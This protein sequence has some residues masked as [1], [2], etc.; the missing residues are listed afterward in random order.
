MSDSVG[1]AHLGFMGQ[2]RD[3]MKVDYQERVSRATVWVAL[4]RPNMSHWRGAPEP[5]QRRYSPAC[6]GGTPCV[7]CRIIRF[8]RGPRDRVS[9]LANG[10]LRV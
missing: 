10:L 3:E 5:L 1:S 2:V 4:F 6:V 7:L 9:G 8:I